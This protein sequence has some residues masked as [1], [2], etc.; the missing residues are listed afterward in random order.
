M[1]DNQKARQATDSFQIDKITAISIT[2]EPESK[3]FQMIYEDFYYIMECQTHSSCKKWVNSIKYVQ[4]NYDEYVEHED[5]GVKTAAN[6]T[7]R[8]RKLNVF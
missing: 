1:Y 4:E 5:E 8:F 3:K 7:S 6:K 2:K